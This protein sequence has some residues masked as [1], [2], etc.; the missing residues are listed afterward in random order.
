M[1]KTACIV[2][3]FLLAVRSGTKTEQVRHQLTENTADPASG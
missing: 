3:A 1:Q 2:Q